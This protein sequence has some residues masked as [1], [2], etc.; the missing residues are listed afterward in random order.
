MLNLNDVAKEISE[1]EGKKVELNIA[2]IKEVLHCLGSL[3]GSWN[4]SD[5]FQVLSKLSRCK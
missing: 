3:M 2:Q 1:I 5:L 4:L